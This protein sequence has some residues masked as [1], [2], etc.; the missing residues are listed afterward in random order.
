ML[1]KTG[2]DIDSAVDPG[3]TDRLEV[4]PH[5]HMQAVLDA[6]AGMGFQP[7]ASTC[8]YSSRLGRGVPFVQEFEFYPSPRFRGG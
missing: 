3:D 4:L 1:L 2:L 7:K 6:V 5:P 8:E